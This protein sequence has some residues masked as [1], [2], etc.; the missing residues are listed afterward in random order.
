MYIHTITRVYFQAESEL[1]VFLTCSLLAT[2]HLC[3]SCRGV[4]RTEVTHHYV[5][6]GHI[7]VSVAQLCL[8][9]AASFL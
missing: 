2:G 3:N 1:A 5:Q 7:S 8:C 6:F 4:F 9:A